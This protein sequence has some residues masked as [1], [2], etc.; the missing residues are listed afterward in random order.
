MP[1]INVQL[2]HEVLLALR[3]V[4]FGPSS[5]GKTIGLALLFFQIAQLLSLLQSAGSRK[6]RDAA[7]CS[8]YGESGH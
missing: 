7:P 5:L 2:S 4:G 3:D 1:S 6:K 8:S